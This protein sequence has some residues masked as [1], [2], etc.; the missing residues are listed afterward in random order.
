MLPLK[1]F[2]IYL[3]QTVKK[4]MTKESVIQASWN[5][6]EERA[7]IPSNEEDPPKD[8]EKEFDDNF[9]KSE[10]EIEGAQTQNVIIE[11]LRVDFLKQKGAVAKFFKVLSEYEDEKIFRNKCIDVLVNRIWS[12]HYP[13]ILKFVFLPYLLYA[14]CFIGYMTFYFKLEVIEI[15]P[16]V[17]N[18]GK[19][20]FEIG[21][22][23]E[24]SLL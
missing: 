12:E 21:T 17:E 8:F 7:L 1:N 23:V 11:V 3:E 13:M 22:K 5:L 10:Q 19:V 15:K 2:L 9:G 6:S 24:S 18:G 4:P 16:Q 14:G 20:K